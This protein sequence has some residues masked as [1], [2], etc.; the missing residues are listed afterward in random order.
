MNNKQDYDVLGFI[1]WL[2]HLL[3]MQVR[4]QVNST[5]SVGVNVWNHCT[6]LKRPIKIYDPTSGS[7]SL[8]INIGL[9]NM[10]TMKIKSNIT[11]KS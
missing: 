8:L 4:K 9:Q 1:I 11:H 3:L 10:S 7:G 2:V 5:W 6:S